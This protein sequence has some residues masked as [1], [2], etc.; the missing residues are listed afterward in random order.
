MMGSASYQEGASAVS[1]KVLKDHTVKQVSGTN[2]FSFLIALQLFFILS[3]VFLKK[4]ISLSFFLPQKPTLLF[5]LLNSV[6]KIVVT[7]SH[8]GK[9]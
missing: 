9:K 5:A 4:I 6:L 2:E 1:A 3:F 7:V 8:S